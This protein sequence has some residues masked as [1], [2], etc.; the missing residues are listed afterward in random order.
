MAEGTFEP[1]GFGWRRL[2]ATGAIAILAVLIFYMVGGGFDPFIAGVALPFAVGLVLLRWPHRAGVVVLGIAGLL[3]LALFGPGSIPLLTYGA[4]AP[5]DYVTSTIILLGGLA[6]VVGAIPA[7]RQGRGS[8]RRSG[9]ARAI[10]V[11]SGV[12]VVAALVT[13][14]V[15]AG[16]FE[17]DEEQAG[18]LRIEAVEFLYEPDEITASAGT[19]SVFFDNRDPAL[20]T[21]TIDELGIDLIAPGDA[22]VR[23]EVEAEAGEYRFYCKPHAAQGMEGTLVVE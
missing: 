17:A 10:A 13:S 12:L 6:A 3:V 7:F 4:I 14:I 18:D 22:G 15:V 9:T 20:H 2:Q 19:L 5:L 8:D 1:E 16:G 11:V 23:E 21:F